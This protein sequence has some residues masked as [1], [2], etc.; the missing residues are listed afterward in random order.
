ML[1]RYTRI[2]FAVMVGLFSTTH[3]W[4]QET[5][6]TEPQESQ[7]EAPAPLPAFPDLVSDF[8]RTSTL[9]SVQR[10]QFVRVVYQEF[11]GKVMRRGRKI[12]LEEDTSSS[13]PI[14]YNEYFLYD[15]DKNILYRLLRDEQVYFESK[16]SVLQRVDAIRKGWVPAEGSFS[17]EGVDVTLSSRDI[18]LR[19]DTLD[20][21]PVDL[22]LREIK[23]EIPAIGTIPEQ[24]VNNYVLVWL[25]R[26]SALPVKVSYA[27]N[28]VNVIIRYRNIMLEP[29]DEEFFI[30]PEDY[31][32]LT[33]Y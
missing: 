6:T 26:D 15:F 29:A 12:Y 4:A 2:M 18:P 13:G 8:T 33:P 17:Y 1:R 11:S 3:L 25:D 19:E 30:I 5:E 31:L 10:K 9:H 23:A 24:T 32:N 22:V 7:A 14:G 20:G 27:R 28:F 21:R 16:L